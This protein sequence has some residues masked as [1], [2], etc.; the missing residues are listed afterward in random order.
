MYDAVLDQAAGAAFLAVFSGNEKFFSASTPMYGREGAKLPVWVADELAK[1]GMTL[2][3]IGRWTVGAG[4][5]SFT[6]LRLA[7]ALVAGWCFGRPHS[8]RAVPGVLGVAAAAGMEC[9]ETLGCLYDGRN[10]ELIFVPVTRLPDGKLAIAAEP[11]ILNAEGAARRFAAADAPR[12]FAA[13]A[14]ELPA[15]KKLVPELEIA[16]VDAPDPAALAADGR[17]FD[18]DVTR[19]VYIRPAVYTEPKTP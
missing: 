1:H 17:P 8:C 16:A 12:R 3:E 9:G 19:L 2:A 13:L 15:L 6:G 11:E 14:P 18:D 4:P 5:G 7:A 10:R